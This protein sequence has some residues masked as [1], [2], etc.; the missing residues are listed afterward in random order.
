MLPDALLT[1]PD[2][3][4]CVGKQVVFVCQE[5]GS[6]LRWTVNLPG[7]SSIVNSASSAQ[8]GTVLTFSNDPG[9]GFEI[10][11]LSSS[12]ASSVISELRVTAVR[13]LNGVTVECVGPSGR[14]MSTIQIASVGECTLYMVGR[15]ATFTWKNGR[16]GFTWFHAYTRICSTAT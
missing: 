13:Q 8:A 5:A 11:V 14:F 7:G 12:S 16:F 3:A 1:P 9:F 15:S 10:H 6:S 2:E 4:V